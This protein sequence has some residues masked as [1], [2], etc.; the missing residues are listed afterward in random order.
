[1]YEKKDKDHTRTVNMFFEAVSS[2]D[3][4]CEL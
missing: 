3:K 1:M 2:A 4:N